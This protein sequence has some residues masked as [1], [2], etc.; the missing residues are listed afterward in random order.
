MAVGYDGLRI[1]SL[2]LGETWVD[3]IKPG[4]SGADDELLLRAI[5][6]GQG[7][8]VAAGYTIWTSPDGKDWEEQ[9]TFDDY[10]VGGLQYGNDRFVAT[11]GNGYAVFSLDAPSSGKV[12]LRS[13]T[14]TVEVSRSETEK[15]VTS[16]G[17]GAWFE[18]ADGAG[19]GRR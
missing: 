5:T 12:G 19:S 2:D 7:L 11:G 6:F 8:F 15:F 16:T 17:D 18:S 9:K 10:W 13:R 1:R 3:E 14:R 4:N